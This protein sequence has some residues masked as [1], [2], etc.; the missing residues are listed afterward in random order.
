MPPQ[1]GTFIGDIDLLWSMFQG[2]ASPSLRRQQARDALFALPEDTFGPFAREAILPAWPIAECYEWPASP[3][4]NPI[5]PPGAAY[6][7][8]PTLVLAGD[9]NPIHGP[10]LAEKVAARYPRGTFV[11]IPNAGQPAF[12][13]GTCGTRIL[14][15]FLKRVKPGRTRCAK[16]ELAVF[17]G[18]GA[19]PRSVAGYPPARKASGADHSSARDR[20]V[21]AAAVHTWRD[22]ATDGAYSDVTSG[23]GL[24]GGAWSVEWG[25]DQ[26]VFKL[27]RARLVRD[28]A[29]SGRIV[30]AYGPTNPPAVL[31]V[32]GRGTDRGRIRVGRH[33]L[34][35]PTR[36]TIRVT[37]RLGGRALHL[38]VPI[39]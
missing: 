39:H 8:G 6:W 34:G 1:A 33:A 27:R 26:G 10:T 31:R 18:V 19:L 36:S 5:L 13:W 29:V 35:D 37:G 24:R 17:P 12:G 14:N 28:V 7:D 2:P 21:V 30:Y 20:R 4:S 15:T 9:L 23:R 22:A 3:R 25:E 32:R 16:H 38:R 11:S